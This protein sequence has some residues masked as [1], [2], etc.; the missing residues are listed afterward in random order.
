MKKILLIIFCCICL[1][2]CRNKNNSSEWLFEITKI[3]K[4]Y[5]LNIIEG[6]IKNLSNV[7]CR[8][9]TID[10]VASNK[11]KKL[12]NL[13]FTIKNPSKGQSQKIKEYIMGVDDDKK[14]PDLTQYDIQVSKISCTK[15][16]N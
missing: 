14:I 1:C 5:G 15:Y 12:K 16:N 8:D 11:N 10:L 4:E 6:K 9:I 7:N 2:G 3:S 13:F